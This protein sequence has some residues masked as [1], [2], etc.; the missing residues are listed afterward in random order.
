MSYMKTLEYESANGTTIKAKIFNEKMTGADQRNYLQKLK[1]IQEGDQEIDGTLEA[2]ILAEEFIKKFTD[3]KEPDKL[4]IDTRDK[5]IGVIME[6]LSP[7]KS[8]GFIV[9]SQPSQPQTHD[10]LQPP[11][12]SVK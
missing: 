5:V 7:S 10:T 12:S 3:I 11:S 2:F 4:P 8:L 1:K 9:G 6:S